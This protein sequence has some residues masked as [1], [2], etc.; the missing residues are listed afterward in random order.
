MTTS[1]LATI[2]TPRT[3]GLT[4]TAGGLPVLTIEPIGTPDEPPVG[5]EGTG[6]HYIATPLVGPDAGRQT[7]IPPMAKVPEIV[8]H[9]RI[10]YA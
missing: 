6:Q 5:A 3:G 8:T 9:Q 10:R 2:T 4:I 7:R 1:N